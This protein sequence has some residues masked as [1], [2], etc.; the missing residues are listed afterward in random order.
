[1]KS[2]WIDYVKSCKLFKNSEQ[3][4]DSCYQIRIDGSIHIEKTEFSKSPVQIVADNS[5]VIT[6]KM[7]KPINKWFAATN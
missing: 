7:K 2:I 6:E 1:M 4:T 3:K 5:P